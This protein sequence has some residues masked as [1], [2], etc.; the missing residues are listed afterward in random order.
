VV[1][2]TSDYYNTEMRQQKSPLVL[3]RCRQRAYLALITLPKP[4][5][6]SHFRP[7]YAETL[8]CT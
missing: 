5:F 8:F 6:L 2:F 1:G 3:L 7:K 4:V